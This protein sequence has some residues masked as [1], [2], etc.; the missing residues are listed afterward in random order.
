MGATVR[1]AGEAVAPLAEADAL[2]WY[3]GAADLAELL[4]AGPRVRWIQLPSAGVEDYLEL[5][6]DGG[7]IWT[8]AKGVYA[9]PCAEHALGLAIAGFR[10][11]DAGVRMPGWRRLPGRTLFGA[12]VVVVGGAGGI[13]QA[14]LRLLKPFGVK[15]TSVRRRAEPTPG[16]DRTRSARGL[17]WD[18][19]RRRSVRPCRTID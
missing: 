13:G 19:G 11:M 3:G 7:R 10:H 15:A 4:K 8:A 12:N 1:E 16:A 6:D 9:N 2:I 5:I 18:S 17:H 14:L